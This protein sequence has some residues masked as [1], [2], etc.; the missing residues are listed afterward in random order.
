MP[1]YKITANR[2]GELVAKVQVLT[3]DIATGK[4]KLVVKRI[5][6][7][8]K[9]TDAKFRKQVEKFSLT[10]EDEIK[11][12]YSDRVAQ[13]KN[14]VLTFSQLA[15]EFLTNIELHLSQ[16]YYDRAIKTVEWFNNYLKDRQLYK[17][18]ISEIRVRDV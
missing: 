13:I 7:T 1:Y 16:N 14:N 4:N 8:E 3:K 10:F 6:N 12:A 2:R 17:V 18:P 11:N 9:L 5:Y 15:N